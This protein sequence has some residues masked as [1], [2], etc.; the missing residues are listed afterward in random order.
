MGILSYKF[1]FYLFLLIN[2]F[3]FSNH[4]RNLY[5]SIDVENV[6]LNIDKNY[7]SITDY[8]SLLTFTNNL[9]QKNKPKI[10]SDKDKAFLSNLIVKGKLKDFTNYFEKSKF[11]IIFSIISLTIIIIW[12]IV[13]I[14]FLKGG[15]IFRKNVKFGKCANFSLLISLLLFLFV[16]I[17]SIYSYRNI[18]NFFFYFNGSICSLMKFFH[19]FKNGI[20]IKKENELN[21]NWPGLLNIDNYLNST[22]NAIEIINKKTQMIFSR[23]QRILK[24]NKKLKELIE[25]LHNIGYVSFKNINEE[26]KT[27]IYPIYTKQFEDLENRNLTLGKIYYDYKINFEQN[28]NILN[29]LYKELSNVSIN[30]ED[31]IF[32]INNTIINLNNFSIL[33]LNMSETFS[34][35]FFIFHSLFYQILWYLFQIIHGFFIIISI[36]TIL[37]LPVYSFIKENSLRLI[38]NFF[39]NIL[40]LLIII[41][42]IVGSFILS[43]SQLSKQL[44]PI[45]TTFFEEDYLNSENSL[46]PKVTNAGNFL[47]KCLNDN[48]DLTELLNLKETSINI[49]NENIKKINEKQSQMKLI[50][51][52]NEYK[53]FQRYID[54]FIGNYYATTNESYGNSDILYILNEITNITNGNKETCSTNDIW[55]STKKNCTDDYI[56][57]PKRDINNRNNER[58]YC[59]IIQDKYD[60][61]NLMKLYAPFCQRDSLNNI[62]NKVLSL[63]KY[64]ENNEN[65]LETLSKALLKIQSKYRTLLNMINEEEKNVKSVI[66]LL[67]KIYIPK[68]GRSSIYDMF[69]CYYLKYNIIDFYDQ[70]LNY[71]SIISEKM[72]FYI[73][74]C[75]IVSFIGIF[76]LISSIMRNSKDAYKL[77]LKERN[78]EMNDGIELLDISESL[79]EEDNEDDSSDD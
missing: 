41:S 6:C 74:L 7:I 2:P 47:N 39:W 37:I 78:K 8:N 16:L 11:N 66:N 14:C 77:F 12:I 3:V 19:H 45:I 55:V 56:Y 70:F 61:I 58:K 50:I 1:S 30:K 21:Y 71:F 73:I 9:F 76:F 38:L 67:T 17:C 65:V 18:K 10:L 20:S 63:T 59:L 60:E 36:L 54:N 13:I 4:L 53:I 42:L 79:S 62:F 48:G 49:L 43:L 51:Q 28:S 57:L 29:E 68:N 23:H 25:D 46:F 15:C 32:D 22:A 69:N 75:S 33:V 72:G 64:Y 52:S 31:F 35:N 34:E 24:E 44:I 5:A 40:F 27:K 26:N